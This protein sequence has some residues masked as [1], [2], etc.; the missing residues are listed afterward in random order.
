MPDAR[1]N[2]YSLK[3]YA[4]AQ[5]ELG[6]CPNSSEDSVKRMT[7]AGLFFGIPHGVYLLTA[8]SDILHDTFPGETGFVLRLGHMG[9]VDAIFRHHGLST[10]LRDRVLDV[11]HEQSASAIFQEFCDRREIPF[12]LIMFDSNLVLT[13]TPRQDFG[14]LETRRAVETVLRQL[15]TPTTEAPPHDT[16]HSDRRAPLAKSASSTT[17]TLTLTPTHSTAAPFSSQQQ[18]QHGSCQSISFL[19][20]LVER[21]GYTAKKRIEGRCDALLSDLMQKL[22]A[23][24]QL[25]VV[26]TD[27]IAEVL[28]SLSSKISLPLDPE[29]LRLVFDRMAKQFGRWKEELEAIY[30]TLKTLSASSRHSTPSLVL[31]IY[32]TPSDVHRV[33]I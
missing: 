22:S 33:I 12:H 16:A 3:E 17:L 13:R 25:T 21:P 15:A 8:V 31:A 14:K 24:V 11:L 27:I 18:Q 23:R 9:L 29:Q 32:S 20:A 1:N 2:N 10:E 26:V 28:Q 30:S 19:W 5:R 4:E 7:K 6:L